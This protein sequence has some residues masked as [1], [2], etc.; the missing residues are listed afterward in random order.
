LKRLLKAR[1]EVRLTRVSQLALLVYAVGVACG[2]LFEVPEVIGVC[3]AL[4]VVTLAVIVG[5]NVRL[6]RILNDTLDIVAERIALR[7]LRSGSQ[8]PRAQA[9]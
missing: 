8:P 3:A 7:P 2:L 9:A 5:E 4:G 6:A 1:C